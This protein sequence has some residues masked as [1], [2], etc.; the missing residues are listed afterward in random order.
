MNRVLTQKNHKGL[1]PLF[2]GLDGCRAGWLLVRWQPQEGLLEA[3]AAPRFPAGLLAEAAATAVDMPIGLPEAGYRACDLEARKLL[4]AAAK[5]RV[6]LGLRRPL[7]RFADYPEA[8]GWAKAT[9]GKGLSKQAWFLL[10]KIRELEAVALESGQ[11]RL[12]EVHPELIFHG[13]AGGRPV[14][15]KKTRAG[16]EQRLALLDAAGLGAIEGWLG[17]FPRRLA[18]P[19]DLLDAAACALAARRIHEGRAGQLPPGAAP[20]DSRGLEMAIRL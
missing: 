12:H 15:P 13:L 20:R 5:S 18:A 16:R 7:L 6:F 10:P 14:A 3:A 2:A 11:S 17:R 4:P 9:Q 1:P 19:D 8:N